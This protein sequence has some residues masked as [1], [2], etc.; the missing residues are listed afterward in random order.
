MEMLVFMVA[1]LKHLISI[2]SQTKVFPKTPKP[3]VFKFVEI[4][5]IVTVFSTAVVC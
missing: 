4:H 3:H 2:N 1:I 5:S